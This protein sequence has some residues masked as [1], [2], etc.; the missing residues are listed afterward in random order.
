MKKIIDGKIYNTET[1]I[2]IIHED[3]SLSVNDFAY[4]SEALYLT[5][6]GTYFLHGEGG[7]LSKYATRKQNTSRWGETIFLLTKDQALEWCERNS[8]DVDQI[9]K[10]FDIHEEG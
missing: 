1:A 4:E 3:N 6:K 10:H 5:K 7:G 8:I 9:A 2:L